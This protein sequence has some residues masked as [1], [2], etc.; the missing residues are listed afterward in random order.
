MVG[1][2]VSAVT[3]CPLSD[4]VE[5]GGIGTELLGFGICRQKGGTSEWCRRW[6]LILLLMRYGPDSGPYIWPWKEAA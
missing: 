3:C 6:D 5:M 2:D 4:E 1:A